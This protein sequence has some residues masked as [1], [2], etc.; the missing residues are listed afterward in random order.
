MKT[1]SITALFVLGLM[2]SGFALLYTTTFS[3][4]Y[5]STV[6][7]EVNGLGPSFAL[8][9]PDTNGSEDFLNYYTTAAP[10][11]FEQVF[12]NY[13]GTAPLTP[14]NTQDFAVSLF[15]QNFAGT[16]ALTGGA[17][18]FAQIGLNIN[19]ADLV[20]GFSLYN[21]AYSIGG[22]FG[23]SDAIFFDG[24]NFTQPLDFST[25]MTLLAEFSAATQT[26]T[27]SRSS[28]A[29]S[30]AFVP[31]STLRIDG[32]GSTSG[33]DYVVDWDM[34]SGDFF[35]INI[36][37]GSNVS[38]PNEAAGFGYLN[39]D[40]FSLNVVPEPSAYAAILGLVVLAGVML[41]RRR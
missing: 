13:G 15:T 39:A 31:F 9:N 32:T 2:H 25:S 14:N 37:A 22:G 28:A 35:D 40:S 1:L 30:S 4:G 27:F 8:K 21:G 41:R 3:G 24:T 16:A 10:T 38:I 20:D 18:A 36:Y 34:A 17:G 12:L 6:F 11:G 5:D 26:F 23:S 7:T 29:T 19:D 33:T